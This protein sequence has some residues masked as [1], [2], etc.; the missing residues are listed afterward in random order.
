MI[1]QV[2]EYF[3]QRKDILQCENLSFLYYF[4]RDKTPKIHIQ[5][6]QH[7]LLH[8]FNGKKVISNEEKEHIIEEKESVFI[9]KGQYFMSEIL[10]VEKSHF[11]GVMVFF[12]DAFLLS[13]FNKY[14]SLNE[15]IISDIENIHPLCIIENSPSLHETMLS[16]KSYLERSTDESL[17]V[18][19][20]FEEIFLQLLQS[21]GSK[22]ILKYFQALYSTS[23]FKFKNLFELQEFQSVKEMIQKSQLSESQFRKFF[24]ELY[25]STPKEWLLK[26]S[27][28]KAKKLLEE[29]SLNVT[30]VCFECGFNSVSWFTKSFKK[31]FGITPKKYQQNC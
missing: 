27:L 5:L 6:N 7:M 13:I 23:L 14:P 12:D 29:K 1:I 30:E 18:Q 26:K 28:N 3:S 21:N 20:K 24:F 16:T 22:Q 15:N 9:S 10:S 25:S 17:L 2:P 19:L 4:N 11:D 31:E 8:I